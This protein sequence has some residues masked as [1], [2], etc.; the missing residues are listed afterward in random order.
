M[1][2]FSLTKTDKNCTWEYKV[3]K[4]G[5]TFKAK[6]HLTLYNFYMIRYVLLKKLNNSLKNIIN[7][8]LVYSEDEEESGEN[9]NVANLIPKVE[10]LRN[11]LIEKYAAYMTESEIEAY[12]MKLDKLAEKIDSNSYKRSRSM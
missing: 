9:G 8:Y 11:I 3:F 10:T 7:L 1:E 2:Y 5:Y 12:L 4:N 6:T